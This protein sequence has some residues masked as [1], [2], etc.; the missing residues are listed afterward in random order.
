MDKHELDRRLRA[1][2]TAARDINAVDLASHTVP[3]ITHRLVTYGHD[4]TK[5]ER[6]HRTDG[7]T[8]QSDVELANALQDLGSLLGVLTSVPGDELAKVVAE[9]RGDIGEGLELAVEKIQARRE[10]TDALKEQVPV[11]A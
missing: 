3:P 11:D 2:L 9:Y 1:V 5:V 6:R 10:A 8:H 7:M 4:H